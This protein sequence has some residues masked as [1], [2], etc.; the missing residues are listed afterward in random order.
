MAEKDRAISDEE[1]FSIFVEDT[2]EQSGGY[3]YQKR[4]AQLTEEHVSVDVDF[5]DLYNFD[6]EFAQRILLNFSKVIPAFDRVIQDKLR[7]AN[8]DLSTKRKAHARVRGLFT[9]TI[10]R[11]IGTDHLEKLVQVK[12]I[13]VRA[14]GK[15]PIIT[16]A[17]F[18]CPN[19]NEKTEVE[20]PG[21]TTELITPMKCEHCDNTKRLRLDLEKSKFINYQRITIQERPEELPPG[22][23]PRSLNVDYYDDLV[24]LVRPGD[25]VTVV[26]VVKALQRK[27]R[28]TGSSRIVDTYIE[29]N[30]IESE[31]VEESLHITDAE[32]KE[33]DELA[34]DPLIFSRLLASIAPSIYGH[35]SEKESILYL[36]FGGV[37][38]SLPDVT[39][40]GDINALLIGDPGTGKSQLLQFAARMAPRGIL[41]TGRGSSAAGLTAAVVRDTSGNY[42]LEAGALVLA[43]LGICCIDELDKMKEEDRGAIHPAMEQQVVPVAKGGIVASLNARTSILASANPTLGRYNPYQTV[44]QNIDLPIT[45]LSRFDLIFVLK[46]SPDKEKDRDL[47]KHV[48]DL[49]RG[50]GSGAVNPV[51]IPLLRKYIAYGKLISPKLTEEASRKFEDFY[52]NMRSSSSEAGE[53]AAISITARQLEGLIRLA[54]A[55]AKAHLRHEVTIEDAEAVISLMQKSLEQ[56]GI[57]ATTGKIDI[58]LLYSGKPKSL[59]TQL[60]KVL[61]VIDSLSKKGTGAGAKKEELLEILAEDNMAAQEAEKL[62]NTLIKDGTIYCPRPG[63]YRRTS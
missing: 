61:K 36:L 35:E 48:M 10:L 26:G 14:T 54:E 13:V 37:R 45:I 1:K 5:D 40:R 21:N 23:M 22:Q 29:G 53:A 50:K 58:D 55:R 17:V 60:Q 44:A 8:Y 38:K 4:V 34:Q 20:Q 3:K 52:V 19:C 56:V 47:A 31:R 63:S 57:D 51:D 6:Q 2:M 43:D 30:N 25:R 18:H 15:T 46:D 33:L 24:D 32:R 42:I 11:S 62:L 41:T 27:S 7:Q 28:L 9:D 39:I 12:G 16:W 59:Q 49:H